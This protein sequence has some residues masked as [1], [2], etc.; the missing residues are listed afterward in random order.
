M[1]CEELAIAALALLAGVI[2]VLLIVV[3][4]FIGW[5]TH[6][7]DAVLFARVR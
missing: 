7:W 2:V 4:T 1:H 3:G 6:E 5:R